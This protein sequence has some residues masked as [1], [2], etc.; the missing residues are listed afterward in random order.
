[1]FSHAQRLHAKGSIVWG[2]GGGNV[3]VL[4][5]EG[6]LRHAL[7]VSTDIELLPP[8]SKLLEA[9]RGGVEVAHGVWSTTTR[10]LRPLR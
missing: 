3:V 9:S 2:Y 6:G 8:A 7:D 1:M 4:Y 5:P 10:W